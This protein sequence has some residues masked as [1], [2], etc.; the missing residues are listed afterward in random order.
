MQR[1]IIHIDCDSFFAS[2]E[3]QCNPLLREK[4]IG[5]TAANG[6]SAIIAASREAKKRGIT[7]PARTY[8]A[9][10][11]CPNIIF[12][13]ADFV[14][15]FEVSKKF[16]NVCKDYSPV[17][18]FF[19]IDELF[20]DVTKTA[21][22]F[23]GVEKLIATIKHRI[24]E[25]IGAYVT[26]SFGVAYNKML[27]KLASGLD[28]PNGVTIVTRQN[29]DSIYQRAKLSNVC[30]I[31]R[32]I[33]FRL[34]VLGIRTLMGLRAAPLGALI[35][36]FGYMEGNFLH[37]VGLGEDISA[38]IPYTKAPEVKSVSRHYCMAR[39]EYDETVILQNIFELCE[40]VGIKLR[41]LHKKAQAVGLFLDGSMHF[42]QI[43]T[44][45]QYVDNGYE[46]FHACLGFLYKDAPKSIL[47]QQYVR[48]IAVWVG[49]LVDAASV[50]ASLFPQERKKENVIKTVDAINEKFGDHTI[51]NGFL[52][53]A[54]KLTTVPNGF[55]SDRYERT[56]LATA[57]FPE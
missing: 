9:Q 42:H 19:S 15:Y 11:I 49:D 3:Q 8:D 44:H 14:K 25:E 16:I 10:K 21:D 34:N 28:K 39:N 48:K 55:G 45:K 43:K 36:E 46:M 23:G 22:L 53:K 13:Q 54:K 33:E 29:L 56:K 4:P 26:V 50:P 6:A 35:K 27:A 5:I 2:V 57:E 41:R 52:L 7:S 47:A 31:G 38:V 12:V 1:T 37:H 18:E 40:E 30:G 32:R 20:M 17:V 24:R 51:R